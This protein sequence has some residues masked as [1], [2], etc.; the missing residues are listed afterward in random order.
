MQICLKFIAYFLFCEKK[1]Y[2]CIYV[3]HVEIYV[4]LG[5]LDP[6]PNL[7]FTCIQTLDGIFARK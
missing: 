5:Q 1:Y 3:K 4:M 7:I 6:W 2:A